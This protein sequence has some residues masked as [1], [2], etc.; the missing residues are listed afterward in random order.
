MIANA[1]FGMVSGT[2]PIWMD[3][4]QCDGN[5]TSLAK[6]LFNGYGVH[7]CNHEKDAGVMCTV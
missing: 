6:C 5:E 4:V 3:D 2:G 7:N 1:Y